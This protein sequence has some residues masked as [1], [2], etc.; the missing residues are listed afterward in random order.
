MQQ[1]SDLGKSLPPCG[2]NPDSDPVAADVRALI[3]RVRASI[4]VIE[5]AMQQADLQ[6]D[7]PDGEDYFILDDVTPRYLRLRSLLD[8]VDASLIA[9]LHDA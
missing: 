3:L 1:S 6:H 5:S 4:T 2:R 8:A 7:G 9:A